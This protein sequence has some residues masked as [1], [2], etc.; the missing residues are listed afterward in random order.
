MALQ[1]IMEAVPTFLSGYLTNILNMVCT[2]SSI[3][4]SGGD[5]YKGYKSQLPVRLKTL[6]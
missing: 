4:K 5:A 1:K 2:H 6:R 3:V